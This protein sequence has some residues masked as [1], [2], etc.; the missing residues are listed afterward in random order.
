MKGPR[1]KAQISVPMPTRP[2]SSQHSSAHSASVNTRQPEVRHRGVVPQ[3]QREVIVR[4]DAQICRLVQRSPQRRD[5]HR[6]RH[7]QQLHR[8]AQRLG[9]AKVGCNGVVEGRDNEPDA[10][11]V[12]KGAQADVLAPEPELQCKEQ[13]VRAQVLHAQ[14]D[15]QHLGQTHIQCA[16]GVVAK[17]RLLEQCN[18]QPDDHN[19]DHHAED[20]P[21]RGH[22][23]VLFHDSVLLFCT[24]FTT[25]VESSAVKLRFDS[26]PV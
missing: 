3:A 14:R 12:D 1:Q 7:P 20:A 18:A 4:G 11:A 8:Q 22:L 10:N 21:R 9:R 2:P 16:D 6:Q 19:T 13:D 26:C 17:V 24:S 23:R 25:F 5:W 15:A